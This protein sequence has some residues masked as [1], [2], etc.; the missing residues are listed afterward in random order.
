MCGHVTQELIRVCKG[1]TGV[2][3]AEIKE[4]KG[5]LRAVEPT[6]RPAPS[7]GHNLALRLLLSG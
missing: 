1:W 2:W 4:R 7:L 6:G 5:I 3:R